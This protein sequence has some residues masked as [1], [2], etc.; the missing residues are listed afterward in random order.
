MALPLK[1]ITVTASTVTL[2][3]NLHRD[4]VT[5]LNRA[6]GIAVTLPLALGSGDR[7]YLRVG[8]T[9]TSLTTTITTGGSDT[10]D[11]FISTATTTTGAGTHEAAGGADHIITMNGTTQG[12][13]IGS[14]IELVDVA[15]TIWSINGHFVGSGTLATPLS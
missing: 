4:T 15:S 6:A 10:Y 2:D 8:V 14:I 11:G 3:R 13:I 5:N 7:Y 1:P 12:G 9:I